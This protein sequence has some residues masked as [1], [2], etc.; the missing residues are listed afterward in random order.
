MCPEGVG[1]GK[2]ASKKTGIP[3]RELAKMKSKKK[4]KP[5]YAFQ[6]FSKDDGYGTQN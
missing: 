6:K 1:Y 5:K 4:S 2:E 3:L